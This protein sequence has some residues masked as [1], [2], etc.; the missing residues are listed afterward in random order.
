MPRHFIGRLLNAAR[1]HGEQSE[2]DME[3]GDLQSLIWKLWGALTPDQRA[4][5]MRDEDLL[6][7]LKEWKP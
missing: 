4:T 2:P 5:V 6:D 3:I 1:A 7:Q